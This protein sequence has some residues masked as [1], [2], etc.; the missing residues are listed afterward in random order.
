MEDQDAKMD[1]P[2][3]S[4]RDDFQLSAHAVH[5]D[6]LLPFMRHIK[7]R[8]GWYEYAGCQV[9]VKRDSEAYI[10]PSDKFSVEEFPYR[11]TC[12]R[13]DD[14]WFLLEQNFIM[15]PKYEDWNEAVAT[16]EVMFT[17]FS[18]SIIDLRERTE[19]EVKL[20]EVIPGDDPS[21]KDMVEVINP[22]AGVVEKIRRDD[23][24]YYSADGFKTRRHEGSSKPMDIPS[25]VWQSAS[26]KARREAIREEQMKLARSG[27][28]KKKAARAEKDL[29]KLEKSKKGVAS[30]IN[31]PHQAYHPEDDDVPVMRTCK[32]SQDRHRVKCARVS[33]MSGEKIIN[34]F[35]ARPVNKTEIRSNPKAQESLDI[36]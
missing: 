14:A 2:E 17:S 6:T 4:R 36:E 3:S 10:S 23:P 13:K 9:N 12:H 30:I 35:V 20:D 1:E 33:I 32:Y 8:E 15:W 24:Q 16:C 29:E 5:D 11:T 26:V 7:D 19:E 27:A 25:F 18:K 34:T 31:Q 28:E 22:S 21:D